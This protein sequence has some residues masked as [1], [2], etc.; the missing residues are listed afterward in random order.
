MTD[1][2]LRGWIDR[3][4]SRLREAFARRV[5]WVTS[6]RQ[7]LDGQSE[8]RF[9]LVA[10]LGREHYEPEQRRYPVRS[11]FDLRNVLDL[12]LV[13]APE[14]LC[15]IGPAD[16]EGRE[17][18]LHKLAARCPR[19]QLRAIFWVPE[20]LL[21]QRV[22]R[23]HGVL[24]V[25]RESLNY[26]VAASGASLIAGG[27]IRNSRVFALA[28][29]VTV[30][31]PTVVLDA[32]SARAQFLPA[33]LDLPA[34]AW[35]GLRSPV[36]IAHLRRFAFPAAVFGAMAM[37]LYLTLASAYFSTM[38]FVRTRQLE[39][40]G[41]Q[42][43][44]LL[45]DQRVI[46]GTATEGARLAEVIASAKPVWP[47]WQL[48]ATV[49]QFKGAIYGVSVNGDLI[50]LRCTAPEATTV[51]EG[52]RAIKEFEDARFDTAVRQGGAGQEFVITLR[53]ST[54]ALGKKS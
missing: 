5:V 40:L 45:R 42:V 17:V 36:A 14:T 22:A 18:T 7:N 15:F 19:D 44:S 43:S 48:V 52:L 21:L 31:E 51:L 24:S 28:T 32:E 25:E 6:D 46:E 27:A 39:A 13:S 41:P 8:S 47:I 10:I 30:E 49:W 35:W 9:A 37:V 23:A 53:R 4:Q 1:F 2:S 50:T 33:L 11:W 34:A 20:T 29:G 54:P 16:T 3:A 12:E 26:F 38:N